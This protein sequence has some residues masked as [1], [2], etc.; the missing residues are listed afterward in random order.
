VLQALCGFFVA[1]IPV[2]PELAHIS[3]LFVVVFAL[4]TYWAVVSW[5]GLKVGLR[6]LIVL[7]L[8]ALAVESVAIITGWP[9][10]EFIYSERIGA[11]LFGLAPWT[12]P[13]AWTPLVCAAVLLARRW[14]ASMWPTIL[15]GGALLVA[16]DLVLDPG[17]V[18]QGFWKFT[19][20]G[21]FYNVPGQNFAGWMLSGSVA[22]ALCWLLA[23]ARRQE[24][25]PTD[26]LG[27]CLLILS[28]WS[29]VCAWMGL[30]MPA[31]IGI[32]LLFMMARL[33]FS[34]MAG[35]KKNDS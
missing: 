17:A 12:V 2:R 20:P 23:Q 31:L 29:S 5:L 25:P 16:I 26:W 10:G 15:M 34:E 33:F 19:A 21:D 8:Y 9:Y 14:S 32:T 24:V 27:S 11:R 30:W 13:F 18:A 6:L 1:K 3:A 22:V 4:P 35:E 28:F 7:G